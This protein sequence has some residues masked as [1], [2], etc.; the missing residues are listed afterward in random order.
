MQCSF[1]M[2][3]FL[4]PVHTTDRA[5]WLARLEPDLQEVVGNYDNSLLVFPV[6]TTVVGSMYRSQMCYYRSLTTAWKLCFVV[7]AIV[8]MHRIIVRLS[9]E[10][11]FLLVCYQG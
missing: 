2:Y 9:R 3:S 8:Q 6:Y 11:S 10:G 4:F 1:S 5:G 7:H